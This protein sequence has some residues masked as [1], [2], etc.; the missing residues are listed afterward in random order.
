MGYQEERKHM[1]SGLSS[2][3]WICRICWI[4]GVLFAIVGVIASAINIGLGL[5][6]TNWLLLSI[7]VFAAG[8]SNC[9]VFAAGLNVYA[10]EAKI[11][12]EE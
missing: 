9:I 3:G 6:G 5:G 8:I 10:F 11:K 4:I 1:T 12:K 7:I 2:H